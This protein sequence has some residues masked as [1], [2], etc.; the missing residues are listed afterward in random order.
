MYVMRS[1]KESPEILYPGRNYFI[2]D[3]QGLA[4]KFYCLISNP[5]SLNA[6]TW[7]Y[8]KY[9]IGT[10]HADNYVV[11]SEY[12]QGVTHLSVKDNWNI[13]LSGRYTCT[14]ENSMGVVANVSINIWSHG[15]FLKFYSDG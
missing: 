2:S 1:D 3:E 6:P 4:Y 8:P 11:E 7:T 15:E 9:V 14:G 10:E 5:Y 12:E 13:L